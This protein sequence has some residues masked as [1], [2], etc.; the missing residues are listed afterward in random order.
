MP[1]L[2]SPSDAGALRRF[3]PG[4][5]Y[6]PR[7]PCPP[8]EFPWQGNG[9]AWIGRRLRRAFGSLGV[10]DGVVVAWLPAGAATRALPLVELSASP[11]VPVN[12]RFWPAVTVTLAADCNA[13]SP[14]FEVSETEEAV[15]WAVSVAVTT[16]DP[17]ELIPRL[18]P[19]VAIATLPAVEVN[20]TSL[21]DDTPK[22]PVDVI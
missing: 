11:V 6:E 9:H 17:E 10:F 8:V 21:P 3:L 15:T 18:P 16:T 12:D 22:C 7:P 13:M 4:S 20:S 1:W 5:L 14:T 2:P 19:V